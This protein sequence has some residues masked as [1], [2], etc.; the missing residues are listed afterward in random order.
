[1][2]NTNLNL[3]VLMKCIFNIHLVTKLSNFYAVDFGAELVGGDN[4]F[5]EDGLLLR[6][7]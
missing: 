6:A 2:I 7:I 5:A 1:M 3:K 4:G